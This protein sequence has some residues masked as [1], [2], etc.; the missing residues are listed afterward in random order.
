MKPLEGAAGF[1]APAPVAG[2]VQGLQAGG[3]HGVRLHRL[4]IEARPFAAAPVEAVR[5]DGDEVPAAAA[6]FRPL[7]AG[8]PVQRFQPGGV[9]GLIGAVL[10][11]DQE[12]LRQRRIAVG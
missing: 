1:L 3:D 8:Q 11:G 10:A 4:L 9:Q 5:A 12:R 7:Q 2:E 6:A